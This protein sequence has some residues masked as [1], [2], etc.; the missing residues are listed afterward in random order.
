MQP[1]LLRYMELQPNP[2]IT[3]NHL[4]PNSRR[5]IQRGEGMAQH[6][7]YSKH[8]TYLSGLLELQPHLCGQ[9]VALSSIHAGVDRWGVAADIRKTM[10]EARIRKVP[11]CTICSIF[12]QKVGVRAKLFCFST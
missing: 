8:H 1:K 11:A 4:Q 12:F 3:A 6:L 5:T 2:F 9:Y 10:A 7:S